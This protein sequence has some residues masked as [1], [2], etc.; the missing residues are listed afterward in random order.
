MLEIADLQV[1]YGPIVAL[2][3]VSMK[4]AAGETVTVIGANGA[5]KSTLL[6]SI[7]G[8]LRPRSGAIL[9]EG[10]VTSGLP[11]SQLI[12]RGVALVP[13]G[14]HVFP[15]MTVRENLD[16]GAYYR[17]D[18]RAVAEDFEKAV[19]IF[20]ILRERLGHAAGGLSGGQQ[21]ML[22]IGRALMSRPRLL[23]LDEPSLGLAPAIVQQLGRI[24]ADLNASGTTILLVE[25]NARMAL[26]LA[27]RAY[28]LATG[29]V[30][31]TGTGRELLDDP[32][33]RESY[34]GGHVA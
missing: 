3:S 2:H 8:I 14:R 20:P 23:M 9:F 25:Q 4:V 6:K 18:R 32:M 28:V 34:L 16:L 5:G 10:N 29:R 22:A 24:I 30:T 31:R 19:T 17:N 27:D 33:V 12:R 26:R 11:S 13:E 7:C 1:T 21:Q 15:E